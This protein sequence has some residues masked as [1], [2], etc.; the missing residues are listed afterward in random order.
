MG[1]RPRPSCLEKATQL[2]AQRSHFRRELET[3][4]AARSYP[5][6]EIDAALARLTDLGYLDDAKTAQELVSLRLSRAGGEGKRRLAAELARRGVAREVGEAALADL[7]PEREL[8][9]ARE[10]ATD[11]A[12]RGGTDP[13]AL[14]RRLERK[15]FSARAIRQV[16]DE[17]G[18][19]VEIE[20]AEEEA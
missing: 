4:L 9:F 12:R 10:H 3:K 16:M 17:V 20:E 14:A 1:G 5:R 8:A 11:F 15:G 18:S 2:L 7:D 13:L 19:E 6:A